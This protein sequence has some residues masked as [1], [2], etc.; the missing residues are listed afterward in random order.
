MQVGGGTDTQCLCSTCAQTQDHPEPYRV[1]P[2]ICVYT[3]VVTTG[4]YLL[5]QHYS[6]SLV[7]THPTTDIPS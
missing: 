4:M 3:A 1:P 2:A 6:F 5:P 7:V